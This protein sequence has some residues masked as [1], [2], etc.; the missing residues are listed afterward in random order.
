M[1]GIIYNRTILFMVYN[2]KQR[3]FKIILG[4]DK[5]LLEFSSKN[6]MK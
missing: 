6:N 3:D 4:V 2:I 5:D 1:L